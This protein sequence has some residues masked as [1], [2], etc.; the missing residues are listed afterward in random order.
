[1]PGKSKATDTAAAVSEDAIRQRAYYLWEA[2]GRPHGKHDHYWT[3]AH[4]EA[5]SASGNGAAKATRAKETKPAKPKAAKADARPARKAA[6][7]PRAA[8][9]AR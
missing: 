2:D 8:E 3:L 5:A 1:M 6:T 7:K 4:Q 9:K